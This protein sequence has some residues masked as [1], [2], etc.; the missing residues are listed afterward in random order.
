MGR[1]FNLEKLISLLT[2]VGLISSGILYFASNNR[3]DAV[4]VEIKDAKSAA[5]QTHRL[6]C[7]KDSEEILKKG[8]GQ[9]C[10]EGAK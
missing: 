2:L 8:L 7:L 6:I 5:V 3:V 10:I 4:E 9:Y 1:F